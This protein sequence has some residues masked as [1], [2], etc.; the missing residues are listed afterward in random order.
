MARDDITLDRLSAQPLWEQLYDALRAQ[1][2]DGTIAPD[3]KLPAEFTLASELGIGRATVVRAMAALRDEALVVFVP[4]RGC[5]SSSAADIA[6]VTR[7]RPS[8]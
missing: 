2:L 4:G 8:R 3:R 7:K 1:I 6:R 5:F